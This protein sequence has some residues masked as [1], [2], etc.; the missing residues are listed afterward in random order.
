MSH[1]SV[2]VSARPLTTR[3][4]DGVLRDLIDGLEPYPPEGSGRRQDAT[5]RKPGNLPL[6]FARAGRG[7][8]AGG[9]TR[10]TTKSAADR[11]TVLVCITC[12]DAADP[13]D[14]PRKGLALANATKLALGGAGNIDVHEV[15][16]LANCSRG[17]SA[18][19]RRQN[20]WT[21]VFG[22]LD[23]ERDGPTLITGARMLAEST[24]GLLPWRGRPDPL[25]R[26]L[27][28]RVPPIDFE[29]EP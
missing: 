2:R 23:A 14:A 27:I 29:G 9:A 16:C 28:A 12:R 1:T 6:I 3:G 17:L 7:A 10:V 22:N 8:S 24:D 21:Y 13:D 4:C 15:R 20:T 18:A 11:T 26:G 19:I 5:T 25:K